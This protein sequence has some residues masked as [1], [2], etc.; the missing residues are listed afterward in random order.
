MR[1]TVEI[2]DDLFRDLKRLADKER[3]S[4]K[5]VLNRSLRRSV[6]VRRVESQ[7]KSYRCPT[8]HMGVVKILGGNLDKALGIAEMLEDGEV[9]RE[10]ELRK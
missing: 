3:T 1:T 6:A 5:T 10:V 7:G 8:F 2:E 9:A 4:L